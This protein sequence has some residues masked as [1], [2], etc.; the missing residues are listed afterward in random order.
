M[1]LVC[2]ECGRDSIIAYEVHAVKVN[3]YEH[4][5]HSVKAHDDDART[6][7][8]DCDWEGRRDQLKGGCD[9]LVPCYNTEES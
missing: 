3:T 8:L 2:P 1:S 5:C 6:R 4:Y 9:D 7:C